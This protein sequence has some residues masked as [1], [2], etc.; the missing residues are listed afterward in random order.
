MKQLMGKPLILLLVVLISGALVSTAIAQEVALSSRG[1]VIVKIGDGTY[2]SGVAIQKDGKILIS[3]STFFDNQGQAILVRRNIDGS[4]DQTFG[5][6]GMVITGFSGYYI[7]ANSMAIQEDG[8]AVLAG[9][10]SPL[11]S[12]KWSG[13]AN[14]DFLIIRYNADGQMDKGFHGSGWVQTDIDGDIDVAYG[15]ALQKDRKIVVIGNTSKWKGYHYSTLRYNEDGA[16]DRGFGKRGKVITRVGGAREDAARAVAIQSDNKIIVAGGADDYPRYG[17][18]MA[19][20]RYKPDG[21]LDPHFGFKGK[22][23]RYLGND[24]KRSSSIANAV[25]V[26]PDGKI[27]AGV[28][29]YTRGSYWIEGRL[30]RLNSDGGFDG[31]FGHYG[32]V[33]INRH[34]YSLEAINDV[35]LQSDGRI[36]FVGGAYDGEKSSFVIVVGRNNADG[37]PDTSFGISGIT[38]VLMGKSSAAGRKIAIQQDGK[39]V[40]AG[41]VGK[42]EPNAISH[43]SSRYPSDLV[44]FRLNADGQL[45]E[46]FGPGSK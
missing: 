33:T 24:E 18:V 35:A 6:A 9:V 39:I 41:D 14:D 5:N 46:T 36:L 44:F 22:V 23:L 45:D 2:A 30:V 15:L 28:N 43:R 7:R 32:S 3:A 20:A 11:T 1:V 26:Q 8:K 13:K 40:I 38:Q 12:D 34:G 21:G 31:K 42:V 10:A 25:T 29:V 17:R 37:S 4:P 27:I 16:L 19:L